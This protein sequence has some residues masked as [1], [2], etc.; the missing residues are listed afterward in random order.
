MDTETA[1]EIIKSAA[2]NKCYLIDSMSL[3]APKPNKEI[4]PFLKDGLVEDWNLYEKVLDYT[5]G[6]HLKCDASKH[7]I[8]MTEPVVSILPLYTCILPTK[9]F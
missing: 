4:R 3:K 6:K 7:P 5:L 1:S 9:S 2:K 8:L